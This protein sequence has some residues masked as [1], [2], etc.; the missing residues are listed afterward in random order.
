MTTTTER[1]EGEK[2]MEADF[3]ELQT[4]AEAVLQTEADLKTRVEVGEPFGRKMKAAHEVE[5]ARARFQTLATPNRVVQLL[6]KLAEIELAIPSRG[7]F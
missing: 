3:A 6:A 7:E 4:A 2:I 1:D 5:L